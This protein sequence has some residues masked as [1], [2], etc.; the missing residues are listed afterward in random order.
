[1]LATLLG[2]GKKKTGTWK[3]KLTVDVMVGGVN[4][5]LWLIRIL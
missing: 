3:R 4:W 5:W 2:L 1:M